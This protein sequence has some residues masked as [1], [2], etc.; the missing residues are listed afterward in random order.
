MNNLKVNG[1]KIKPKEKYSIVKNGAKKIA[2]W[3]AAGIG[4]VGTVNLWFPNLVSNISS[5]FVGASDMNIFAKGAFVLGLSS[6]P[7]DMVQPLIVTGIGAALG[8]IAGS[9]VA[10]VKGAV[11]KIKEGKNKGG[12]IK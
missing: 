6:K 11:H 12:K 3:G 4:T 7:V 1:E 5:A 9:S 2:K 8:V 10:L